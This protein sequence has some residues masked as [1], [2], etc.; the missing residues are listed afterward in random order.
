VIVQNQATAV[1]GEARSADDAAQATDTVLHLS[2]IA[3]FVTRLGALEL[4]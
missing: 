3:L 4:T 2:E 1:V